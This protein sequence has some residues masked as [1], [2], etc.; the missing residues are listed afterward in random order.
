MTSAFQSMKL[1]VAGLFALAVT[2][3]A[4]STAEPRFDAVSLRPDPDV[5]VTKVG[6]GGKGSDIGIKIL[7]GTVDFRWV[8]ISGMVQRAYEL[9]YYQITHA[10]WMNNHFSGRATFPANTP[11]DHVPAMMRT[12]LK[13]RFQLKAH[14]ET[15]I[16]K[17]WLLEQAPGGAKLAKSSDHPNAVVGKG[18]GR[19]SGLAPGQAMK[20]MSTDPNQGRLVMKKGTMKQFC[21]L[22]ASEVDRLVLDRTGLQD[23]YDIDVEAATA[24]PRTIEA[25]VMAPT[26]PPPL[27]PPPLVLKPALKKLGLVLRPA[28]ESVEMLVIDS[29]QPAPVAQ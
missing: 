6:P 28:K 24:Y 7:P 13:E 4:Q 9:P 2:A 10:D 19:P 5:L 22:L 15:R 16:Q 26:P 25:P 27:R 23:E 29:G 18:Y 21:R 11:L 14:T 17:L 1:L 3:W 20:M 8:T 12:M